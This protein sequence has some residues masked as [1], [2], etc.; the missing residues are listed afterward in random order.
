MLPQDFHSTVGGLFISPLQS[1]MSDLTFQCFTPN[2][3]GLYVDK[4]TEGTLTVT[5]HHNDSESLML[6][7][8]FP[9]IQYKSIIII[10]Y[11]LWI[12]SSLYT[13]Y[14][15]FYIHV[16]GPHALYELLY[17]WVINYQVI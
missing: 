11:T 5:D 10:C 2:G 4:S 7:N 6:S 17:A 12:F 15:T 14:S 13:L 16:P 1:N 9:G 3:T 8:E